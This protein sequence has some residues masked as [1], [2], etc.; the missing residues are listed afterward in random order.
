MLRRVL[1]AGAGVAVALTATQAAAA[2]PDGR[3][4]GDFTVTLTWTKIT[5]VLDRRVGQ[6]APRSFTFTPLCATGACDTV[7]LVRIAGDGTRY[8]YTLRKRGT[9]YVGNAEETSGYYCG[10]TLYRGARK[11]D[12]RVEVTPTAVRTVAGVPTVTGIKVAL[13][14]AGRGGGKVGTCPIRPSLEVITGSGRGGS[15]GRFSADVVASAAVSARTQE[16][17]VYPSPGNATR[18]DVN[19]GE[20]TSGGAN[21]LTGRPKGGE[22]RA[23]HTYAAAGTYTVTAVVTWPGGYTATRT[24]TVTVE[25][26]PAIEPPPAE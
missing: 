14:I 23:Q 12:T 18:I 3:L 22:L 15:T 13:R 16:I 1:V 11:A 8:R 7:R 9:G 5:N 24:T 4:A 20:P 26:P 19:F 25:D 17:A 21:T 2:A 10:Q 6:R